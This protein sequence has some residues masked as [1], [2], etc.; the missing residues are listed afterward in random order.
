MDQLLPVLHA[1]QANTAKVASAVESLGQG[2]LTMCDRLQAMAESQQATV[3]SQ[4]A[5]AQLQ[6]TT[7]KGPNR[8]LE[9][10]WPVA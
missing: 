9:I 5:T 8:L 7:V 1:S 2:F 3:E 10:L 6:R 4:R